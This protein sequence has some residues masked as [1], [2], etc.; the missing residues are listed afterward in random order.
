MRILLIGLI[1]LSALPTLSQD[2]SACGK[3]SILVWDK[4]FSPLGSWTQKLWFWKEFSETFTIKKGDSIQ[5]SIFSEK[6][7]KAIFSIYDSKSILKLPKDTVSKTVTKKLNKSRAD[8]VVSVDSASSLLKEVIFSVKGITFKAP[9]Y[10][11]KLWAPTEDTYYFKIKSES[12][13]HNTFIVNV[14]RKGYVCQKKEIKVPA[15]DPVPI[16]I[17]TVFQMKQTDTVYLASLLNM[18]NK[19]RVR[20]EIDSLAIPSDSLENIENLQYQLHYDIKTLSGSPIKY[21][22]V[23]PPILRE[24]KGANNQGTIERSKII[25]KPA[26]WIENKDEVTGKHVSIDIWQVVLAEKQVKKK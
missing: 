22:F 17:D 2:N 26:L 21:S 3:D 14:M 15:E 16:K 1:I 4:E 18:K 10:S 25:H 6:Q 23:N 9:T 13:F 12:L 19:H 11:G 20:F 7:R 8:S 5:Y 24:G